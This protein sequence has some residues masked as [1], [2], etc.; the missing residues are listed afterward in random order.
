MNRRGLF[1]VIG[2]TA[3]TLLAGCSGTGGTNTAEPEATGTDTPTVDGGTPS[4]ASAPNHLR[5]VYEAWVKIDADAFLATLHSTN[6]HP[7][8]EVRSSAEDLDFEGTLVEL[9]AE[10]VNDTPDADAISQLFET[11]QNL[12]EDDVSTFTDIQAVVARVDPTVDG[13]TTNDAQEGFKSFLETEKRHF[14]A[15]E[16]G[17]WRFVL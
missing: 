17:A 5:T 2:T 4:L 8:E 14:L 3:A 1:V 10:I 7:E 16:N 13:E 11:G 12:S 15:V 9:N 6:N